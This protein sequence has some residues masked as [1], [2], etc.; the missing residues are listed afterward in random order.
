MF[1]QTIFKTLVF[2]FL[3]YK[4]FILLFTG[5]AVYAATPTLNLLISG[6]FIDIVSDP[7]GNSVIPYY[8]VCA[9]RP[10]GAQVA[11]FQFNDD[12]FSRTWSNGDFGSWYMAAPDGYGRCAIL[13]SDTWSSV[14]EAYF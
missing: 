13:N 11:F 7:N 1:N 6:G 4:S 8:D 5:G 14:H 3:M 10:D 2:C 12:P 9:E